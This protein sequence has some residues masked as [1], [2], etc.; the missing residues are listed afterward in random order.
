MAI[1]VSGRKIVTRP[2]IEPKAKIRKYEC[3]KITAFAKCSN[4]DAYLFMNLRA[5]SSKHI[6][7]K[8]FST[9]IGKKELAGITYNRK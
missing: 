9:L 1:I 5:Q 2:F 8:Y 6:E 7:I 3:H 4:T